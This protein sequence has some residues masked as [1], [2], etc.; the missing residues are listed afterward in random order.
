MINFIRHLLFLPLYVSNKLL[1]IY[2]KIICKIDPNGFECRLEELY[3]KQINLKTNKKLNNKI[4]DYKPLLISKKKEIIFYTPTKWTNYRANSL[5][6][7]E[8]K[9]YNGSINME[10]GIILFLI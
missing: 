1:V 8:K 2:S 9:L 7:K 5:F 3:Q 10:R 6:I 4:L